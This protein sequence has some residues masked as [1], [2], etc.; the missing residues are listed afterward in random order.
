MYKIIIPKFIIPIVIVAV[1]LNILR[2]IIWGKVSFVFILWNI[3][4]A[5]IPYVI[6]SLLLVYIKKENFNKIIFTIGCILWLLFIPNAPYIITDFIHLGDTRSIPL[7]FDILLLFSSTIIGLYFY[8]RSL[9]HIEHIIT[10][11]YSSKTTSLIMGVII[12]LISFG[13]YLGRFLRFNS[14]DIFFNHISLAKN[15]LKIFSRS[16]TDFGVYLYTG[17]LFLFLLLFY[18]AYKYSIQND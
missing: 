1:T 9:F 2:V 14:W 10:M 5:F 7:L 6:S 15:I 11:K 4:L 12:L 8:F 18:R 16:S 17:L 3:I 13:I